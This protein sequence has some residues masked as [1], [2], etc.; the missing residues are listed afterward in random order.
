[1]TD[2][3]KYPY[4]AFDGQNIPYG[5]YGDTVDESVPEGWKKLFFDACDRI[6]D[7]LSDAGI[8]RGDFHFLQVKEKFGAL[9]CYWHINPEEVGSICADAADD[10]IRDILSDLEEDTARTCIVCGETA[11][12]QTT[13][14]VLPYCRQCA[15]KAQAAANARH[16]TNF[17]VEQ[18]FQ[19]L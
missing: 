2:T 12:L 5:A 11:T 16:K 10:E 6:N 4:L 18:T 13:G 19:P 1:M 14:W 17:S 3:K 9:R 7:V 8:G 15:E